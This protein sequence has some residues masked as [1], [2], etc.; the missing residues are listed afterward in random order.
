LRKSSAQR[1]SMRGMKPSTASAVNSTVI[2]N[3]LI[4]LYYKITL[5]K[6]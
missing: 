1:Q 6:I 3:K 4:A 5:L 2:F